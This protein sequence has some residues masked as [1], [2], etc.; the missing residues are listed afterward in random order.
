MTHNSNVLKS[1]D[2]DLEKLIDYYPNS[3]LI[4]GTEFHDLDLLKKY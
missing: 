1:F 2:C 4:Y 3:D